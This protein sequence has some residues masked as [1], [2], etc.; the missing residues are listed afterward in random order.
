MGQLFQII[1]FL[2]LADTETRHR[3]RRHCLL[4]LIYLNE[5]KMETCCCS[6]SVNKGEKARNLIGPHTSL[7]KYT[8]FLTP[9]LPL[10]LSLPL[11]CP[12]L[13][14]LLPLRRWRRE[15]GGRGWR[16]NRERVREL[17]GG[18]RRDWFIGAEERDQGRVRG[19][20][21]VV[22]WSR[23]CVKRERRVKVVIDGRP[24]LRPLPHSGQG[25]C[26]CR[27]LPALSPSIPVF[28]SHSLL[29]CCFC[30]FFSSIHSHHDSHSYLPFFT[31][32]EKVIESYK[33]TTTLLTWKAF[34]IKVKQ[35]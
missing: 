10:P 2:V 3:T 20:G 6:C 35:N 19:T 1:L 8:H 18:G 16:R 33:T 22:E 23:K 15:R 5:I 24:G 17:E 21:S 13:T 34:Y 4:S 14:F 7:I 27:R 29:L 32:S 9:S 26:C 11:V 12:P 25:A 31:H 30:Y 28:V